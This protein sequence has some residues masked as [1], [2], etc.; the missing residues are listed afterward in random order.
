MNFALHF[1]AT[2]KR[3]TMTI[4]GVSAGTRR[5]LVDQQRPIKTLL[6]SEGHNAEQSTC[7]IDFFEKKNCRILARTSLMDDSDRN[8][9]DE[10][11]YIQVVRQRR[12]PTAVPP[13]LQ[14]RRRRKPGKE[15]EGWHCFT[16][17]VKRTSHSRANL[18]SLSRSI[19]RVGVAYTSTTTSQHGPSSLHR[20]VELTTPPSY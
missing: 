10:N 20:Y 18:C 16:E 7:R 2:K 15:E 11:I 9:P 19:P 6:T 1:S 5:I 3:A 8:H 14:W 13:L 12:V 17:R 4:S